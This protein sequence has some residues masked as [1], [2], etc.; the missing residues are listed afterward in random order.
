MEDNFFR[1]AVVLVC[2]HTKEG[3]FGLIINR[4]TNIP[5][6]RVV[7]NFPDI[8]MPIFYGGPVQPE[9]LHYVHTLGPVIEGS[10]H[11][12][13]G[14]WWGGHYEMVKAMLELGQIRKSQIRFFS[15]Y[16]GWEAGQLAVELQKRDWIVTD[17]TEEILFR[18]NPD[19]VWKTALEQLG[20]N[21]RVLADFHENQGLN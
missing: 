4:N 2:D 10:I 13:D 11:I 19:M 8:K 5:L 7:E 21:Y 17:A 9:T 20:G 1:G 14:I 12:R 6:S 15:G 3:T 16:S 18:Q